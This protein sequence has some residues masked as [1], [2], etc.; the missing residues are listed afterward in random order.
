MNKLSQLSSGELQTMKDSLC[1]DYEFRSL[2]NKRTVD[3]I[4]KRLK[5][6]EN[7]LNSR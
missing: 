1:L 3:N 5:A 6:V 2:F 7:E 4:K